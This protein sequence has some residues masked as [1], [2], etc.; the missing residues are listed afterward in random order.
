M[1]AGLNAA[2]E[3]VYRIVPYLAR[4]F[5]RCNRTS[6]HRRSNVYQVRGLDIISLDIKASFRR[7]F[8]DYF[9]RW[10]ASLPVP[11]FPLKPRVSNLRGRNMLWSA[12]EKNCTIYLCCKCRRISVI[13]YVGPL[14][15]KAFS[16]IYLWQEL[17]NTFPNVEILLRIVL[18]QRRYTMLLYR[19][20]L[21]TAVTNCS[22]QRFFCPKASQEP[23]IYGPDQTQYTF[24]NGHRIWYN[25][26]P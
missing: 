4:P 5:M 18:S 21:S 26:N 15:V 13:S 2:V 17:E 3:A 22:G 12:K 23:L 11:N 10:Q 8:D 16:P 1:F 14:I 25:W 24:Y 6:P 19:L 9:L 7:G 20:W